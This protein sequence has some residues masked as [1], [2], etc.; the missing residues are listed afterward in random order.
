MS[1][2]SLEAEDTGFLLPRN[3]LASMPRTRSAPPLS[4][5]A[6]PSASKRRH[7]PPRT[8]KRGEA[9]KRLRDALSR[10]VVPVVEITAR[11]S[12]NGDLSGARGHGDSVGGLVH[13]GA[14][15]SQRI[16]PWLP[17]IPV[18]PLKHLIGNARQGKEDAGQAYDE[19]ACLQLPSGRLEGLEQILCYE[20][21]IVDI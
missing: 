14:F 4:S 6:S 12:S 16:E 8:H 18:I 9:S 20:F 7:G 17:A 5:T 2:A 13:P 15:A 10:F 3:L 11:N 21:L 19:G 1:S